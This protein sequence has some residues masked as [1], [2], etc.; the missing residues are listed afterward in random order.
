MFIRK[1]LAALLIALSVPAAAQFEL[2]S[3]AYEVPLS[4]L[5][6]PGTTNGTVT[7]RECETCDYHTVR[8]NAATRYEANDQEF[9]LQAFREELEGVQDAGNV[10][11][12]VLRHLESDTIKEIR[13]WF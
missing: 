7:F 10:T 2:V 13:V 5:R 6:L 3:K 4:E 12:T 8:V 11:A 1:L 9:A